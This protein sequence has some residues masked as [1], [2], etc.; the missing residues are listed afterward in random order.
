M[1][2]FLP[3]KVWEERDCV[4]K[5]GEEVCGLGSRALIVTGRHSARVTGALDDVT[6]VLKKNGT[7]YV[8]FD[9]IEENPSVETIMKARNA[10]LDAGVDFVIGI[11]GGSPMDAAKAIALMICHKDENAEYLFAQADSSALP[12]VEIP[13]T[14]GTGSEVTAVSILTR[15]DRRTKQS[16]PHRIFADYALIDGK[17]LEKAPLQ[18]MRNTAVDALAH[19]FESAVNVRST[20]FSRMFVR[21]GLIVWSRSR[22]VL[23]GDREANEEDYRNLMTAAAM[24]GMAIAHTG[25]TLPHG[26]S[27]ILTYDLHMPH[28]AAVGYFQENYLRE[29]SEKDRDFLLKT[30]GFQNLEDYAD[31]YKRVCGG[32]QVPEAVLKRTYEAILAE[33]ARLKAVPFQADADVLARI[34]GLK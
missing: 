25:T 16:L 14:C 13:T 32:T 12:L 5:H 3:V 34:V 28:G 10:G 22:D 9:Q 8:L 29:A 26:L 7:D 27:Y 31:F 33:P 19:M 20:D 1:N 18:M 23:T 6:A 24:G 2:Y 17:Y 11:G 21:Q 30:A 15:H 4:H